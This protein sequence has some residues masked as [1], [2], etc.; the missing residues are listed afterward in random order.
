MKTENLRYD[1]KVLK[2]MKE[3]MKNTNICYQK[4]VIDLKDILEKQER[5]IKI[6]NQRTSIR[7][8]S[9]NKQKMIVKMAEQNEKTINR[10]NELAIQQFDKKMKETEA[11]K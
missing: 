10:L 11:V 1:Q 7:E 6:L 5:K 3:R 2:N 9:I 4:K 8:E